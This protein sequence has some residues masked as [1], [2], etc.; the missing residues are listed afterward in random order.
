MPVKAIIFHEVDDVSHW[1][2]SPMREKV[3]AGVM[4]DILTF[5]H[6]AQPNMVGLSGT[7]LDMTKFEAVMASEAAAAAMKHDG[8]RPGT[9]QLLVE[10]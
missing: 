7:I 3:F 2:A 6:P 10:G 4:E 1:R 8:V 9:V 5:V